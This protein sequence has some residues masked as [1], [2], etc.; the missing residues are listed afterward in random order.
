MKDNRIID[1]TNLY[2]ATTI[3]ESNDF[4]YMLGIIK[5]DTFIDIRTN[6]KYVREGKVFVPCNKSNPIKKVR[7]LS[8]YNLVDKKTMVH[9]T[10]VYVLLWV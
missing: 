2:Y 4:G 5:N 1:T 8:F 9:L 3:D 6:E 7:G 10:N